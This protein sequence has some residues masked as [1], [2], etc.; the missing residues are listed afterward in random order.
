ME[1][2]VPLF[3]HRTILEH[4]AAEAVVNLSWSA[5][6]QCRLIKQSGDLWNA[7]IFKWT[8]VAAVLRQKY[9][10]TAALVAA[11]KEEQAEMDALISQS[12]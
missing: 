8:K 1:R 10:T 9:G 12:V 2:E 3:R 6:M 4:E 7:F 11:Y 5:S